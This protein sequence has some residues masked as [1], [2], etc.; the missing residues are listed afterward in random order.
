MEV[1]SESE[2]PQS[3]LTPSDPM[4]CSPPGSSVHGIFPGKRTGVGCHCLL[5]PCTADILQKTGPDFHLTTVI[6]HIGQVHCRFH[7]HFLTNAQLHVCYLCLSYQVVAPWRGLRACLKASWWLLRS[8]WGEMQIEVVNC[9]SVQLLSCILLFVT[10]WTVGQSARLLY[11]WNSPGMNTGVVCHSLLQ[12]IFL[13]QRLDPGLLH[14]R[15]ILYCLSH[16]GSPDKSRFFI[17]SSSL[18]ILMNEHSDRIMISGRIFPY[19]SFQGRCEKYS[20]FKI[21]YSS[22]NIRCLPQ[23]IL[24]LYLV[25]WVLLFE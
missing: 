19:Q 17:S 6:I 15:L 8:F 14:C 24:A 12:G 9:E 25:A 13:T 11:P 1:K 22:R 16:Q 3:C 10:P 2:V 7:S 20:I 21:H 5:R 18:V 4:D 23:I